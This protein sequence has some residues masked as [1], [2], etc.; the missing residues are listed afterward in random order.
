M[1][2]LKSLVAIDSHTMGEPTRVIVDGFPE[3]EGGDD[4]GKEAESPDSL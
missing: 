4:D 2:Q 1:E 3:V